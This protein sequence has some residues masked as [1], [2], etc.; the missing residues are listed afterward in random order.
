MG[1]RRNDKEEKLCVKVVKVKNS[2]PSVLS[3]ASEV[4]NTCLVWGVFVVKIQ[5]MSKGDGNILLMEGR[6]DSK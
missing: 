3:G 6:V 5:R 4:T 1:S 2:S